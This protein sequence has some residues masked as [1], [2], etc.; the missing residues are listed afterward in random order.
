MT[1]FDYRYMQYNMF[2]DGSLMRNS[3]SIEKNKQVDDFFFGAA[4]IYKKF[5]MGLSALYRSPEFINLSKRD[6]FAA[7]NFSIYL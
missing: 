3:P 6:V 7:I 5:R 2:L 1:G 4:L